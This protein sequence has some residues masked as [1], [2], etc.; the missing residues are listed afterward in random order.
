MEQRIERLLRENQLLK[1]RCLSLP[2]P[3]S[4]E[5]AQAEPQRMQVQMLARGELGTC[6]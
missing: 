4:D 6:P 2:K 5:D 3:G 1:Y